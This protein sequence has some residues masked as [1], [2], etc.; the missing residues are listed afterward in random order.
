MSE[1]D[2]PTHD[3]AV[4]RLREDVEV[5]VDAAR[6]GATRALPVDDAKALLGA[7]NSLLRLNREHKLLKPEIL[8]EVHRLKVDAEVRLDLGGKPSSR[9]W[10][11]PCCMNFLAVREAL[12]SGPNGV[13]YWPEP[14]PAL[15][16]LEAC[17]KLIDETANQGAILLAK[18]EYDSGIMSDEQYGAFL[19]SDIG[20]KL[21][22]SAL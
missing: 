20:R 4:E 9:P 18:K 15:I 5:A 11:W 7:A 6:Y 14:S 3:W 2:L 13:Y 12:T 17:C 19:Q 22:R 16:F 21:C 10:L 8:D 1:A